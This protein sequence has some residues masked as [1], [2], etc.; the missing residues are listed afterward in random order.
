[1]IRWMRANAEK[2]GIDPEKI[3]AGG[4]SAGGHLAAAT[5]TVGDSVNEKDDDPAISAKPNALMLFNPAVNL[6][7]P[8]VKERFGE[9]AYKR[10]QLISPHQNLQADLPP[11]IIFHGEDDSVVSFASQEAFV[12]KAKELG[13]KDVTLVGYPGKGH[14][15]FNYGRADGKDYQDTVKKA[16][17]MLTRLGW[18]EEK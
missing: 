9:E 4:G 14:G 13:A 15:F 5:A 6:A 10:I 16:D 18:L 3:A 8:R 12:E 11:T 17:S 2:L 1:M 7:N